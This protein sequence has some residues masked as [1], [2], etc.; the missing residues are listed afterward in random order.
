MDAIVLDQLAGACNGQTLTAILQIN[1]GSIYGGA[2]ASGVTTYYAGD[3]IECDM[4]LSL[5]PT[6]GDDANSVSL[7]YPDCYNRT[8]PSS[9]FRLYDVVSRDVSTA[10]NGLVIQIA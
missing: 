5:D 8:H 4:T 9:A 6:S 2:N 10:S 3:A 1:S 7:T